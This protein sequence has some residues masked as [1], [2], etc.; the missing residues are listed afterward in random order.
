MCGCPRP[1]H[2]GKLKGVTEPERKRKIIGKVHRVMFEKSQK[3]GKVDFLAGH[4]L[5]PTWWRAVWAEDP[6]SS[7]ATARW[8]PARLYVDFRGLVEPLRNLFKDE[9]RQ[10]GRELGLPSIWSA[11]SRFPGPSH[12]HPHHRQVTP[13]KV[14]IVRDL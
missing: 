1:F 10:A 12:R 4:H 11:V 14:T 13:E 3:I 2:F 9:V 7:R 6:P 5:P 8:R